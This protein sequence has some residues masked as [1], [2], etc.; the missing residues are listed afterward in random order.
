MKLE[1]L[2]SP[3]KQ[4]PIEEV[5]LN[6]EEIENKSFKSLIV[7][8]MPK[9]NFANKEA[10]KKYYSLLNLKIRGKI[11]SFS[12][13]ESGLSVVIELTIESDGN[14]SVYRIMNSSGS[15]NFD[16]AM[17]TNLAEMSFPELP[18]ELSENSPYIVPIRINT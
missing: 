2:N 18:K 9:E 13:L 5:A 11:S 3:Q 16:I 17:I 15:R 1:D 14:A 7:N 6:Q 8:L 4:S 12:S 10:E